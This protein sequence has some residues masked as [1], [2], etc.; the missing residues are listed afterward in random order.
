[1]GLEDAL[2][3]GTEIVLSMRGDAVV[4][5]GCLQPVTQYCQHAMNFLHIQAYTCY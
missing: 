5:L 4:K 3:F 1:M 2:F